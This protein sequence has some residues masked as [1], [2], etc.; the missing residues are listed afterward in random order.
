M[1]SQKIIDYIEDC[2][3][4]DIKKEA[5]KKE[6]LSAGWQDNQI[7]E[8]F[9]IVQG[10][11]L[12]KNEP[13][14]EKPKNVSLKFKILLPI[15]LLIIIGVVFYFSISSEGEVVNYRDEFS[16][17]L[18]NTKNVN[19]INF[20][21]GLSY[22]IDGA[23]GEF[24]G[25][26]S[27]SNRADLKNKKAEISL[28]GARDLDIRETYYD[29]RF[30]IFDNK[31]FAK[32][33]QDE[34][35]V[36]S[37][38][39]TNLNLNPITGKNILVTESFNYENYEDLV[40]KNLL[41]DIIRSV[42]REDL[43]SITS[44]EEREFQL[45]VPGADGKAVTT[46]ESYIANRHY[47]DINSSAAIDLLEEMNRKYG[48]YFNISENNDENIYYCVDSSG[49]SN[50]Y[51][52]PITDSNGVECSDIFSEDHSYNDLNLLTIYDTQMISD[53][54]SISNFAEQGYYP[55][56]ES[57]EGLDRQS[58]YLNTARRIHSCSREIMREDGY[59]I[60]VED[61]NYAIW[62]A[63]CGGSKEYHYW[64]FESFIEK[65]KENK[66]LLEKHFV[67]SAL[68]YEDNVQ[69]LTIKLEGIE[70][71]LEEI[72]NFHVKLVIDFRDQNEP[73]RLIK[74]SPYIKREEALDIIS[75]HND[76]NDIPSYIIDHFNSD[77]NE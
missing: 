8:A 70:E 53:L 59:Q 13:S 38:F 50:H 51:K 49:N 26:T 56:R 29:M 5:I 58:Y 74:P 61:Q 9:K 45:L 24:R 64:N 52:G 54:K 41:P 46:T 35:V 30:A 62:T 25:G 65:I 71:G 11:E 40:F 60:N 6:L 76:E 75:L 4:K 43:F 77:N 68:I 31:F 36:D 28:V 72:D 18:E 17:M 21:M 33:E 19:Y 44:T 14:K 20:N 42:Q 63:L 55:H 23:I 37:L 39:S 7:E 22:D 32:S 66:E 47:F 67:M 73:L 34:M 48:S 2:L 10:D 27:L 1:P 69:N 3:Q 57:Y 15:T 16:E 12:K